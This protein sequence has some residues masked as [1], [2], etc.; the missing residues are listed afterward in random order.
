MTNKQLNTEILERISKEKF[1]RR[2]II[3]SRLLALVL[4][5]S[6]F[7]VAW[8]QMKYSKDVNK[9]KSQ[10][11]SLGYCYLCGLETYRLCSCQ[12][13]NRMTMTNSNL[14]ELGIITANNNILPCPHQETNSS[15]INIDFDMLTNLVNSS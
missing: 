15:M 12:Y 2:V 10:Y 7:N 11:G 13:K 9:L 6:I 1:R 3:A 14:T 5:I 8:V 4:I